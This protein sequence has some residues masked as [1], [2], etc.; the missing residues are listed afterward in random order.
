MP[1]FDAE[2][3]RQHLGA[4]LAQDEGAVGLVG[5]TFGDVLRGV[6]LL[7]DQPLRELVEER[8]FRPPGALDFGMAC[9]PGGAEVEEG[10][11]REQELKVG[12]DLGRLGL[13]VGSDATTTVDLATEVG[14][15]LFARLGRT[16]RLAL[17]RF[18][19]GERV[20]VE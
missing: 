8:R 10:G 1:G 13:D 18:D 7:L 2:L 5:E 4:D 12:S 15:E 6:D 19:V 20:V 3:R 9:D 17:A 16:R 14:R 11:A